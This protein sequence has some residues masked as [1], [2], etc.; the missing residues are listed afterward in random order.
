MSYLIKA[1]DINKY[2]GQGL[3]RSHILKNISIEVNN[4]DF[5]SLMGP[6]GSGKSTLLFSISGMDNV[7][8]GKVV[9]KGKDLSKLSEKDLANIRRKEMGFVFQNPTFLS[10]MSILDNII[11]PSYNDHKK[12]KKELVK[13]AKKLME[14]IGIGGLENRNITE[15]SGG[16]LQRAGICRASLHNPDILFADEP[17]GAL[18]SKSSQ[19]VLDLIEDLNSKSMTILLVTHDPKVAAR[20][21]RII[22]MKDG[23]IY[24]NIDL[25]DKNFSDKLDF[26]LKES[27]KLSI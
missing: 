1:T 27:K 15:V 21:K 5:I 24:S 18:N 10:Q 7:D 16:E 9:F 20:A 3:G 2:F 17:T 23:E 6:S 25:S 4:G 14:Y 12:D 8:S 19:K 26:I 11:L 13:D 22:F